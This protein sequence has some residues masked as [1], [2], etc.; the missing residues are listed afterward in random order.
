[1]GRMAMTVGGS[2]ILENIKQASTNM[3]DYKGFEIGIAAGP[4]DP[5]DPTT[6]NSAYLNELFAIRAGSPNA[7]AAWDF[8]KFVNGEE[9]AKVKSKTLNNGL[10]TR[11]GISKEYNGISLEAF[12][13]LKPKMALDSDNE[14]TS[15]PSS[16][17]EKYQPIMER[18]IKLLEENKKTV[19]EALN[20]IQT[21]AQA[22]LDQAFK[23]EEAQKAQ[24]DKK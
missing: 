7:D 1:M 24:K 14:L 5:S 23:D 19:D 2:N 16:F 6:T 9:F 18:E 8:I 13:K 3:K 17:Y 20:T 10:P 15:I 22:A 4:V 21:E 11:E 12:Y